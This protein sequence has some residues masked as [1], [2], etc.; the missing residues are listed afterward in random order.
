MSNGSYS[1][2]AHDHLKRGIALC[3]E[4]LALTPRLY[5]ALYHLALAQ[6]G[7]KQPDDALTTYQRALDVCSAKGVVQETLQ[8]LELLT[9]AS[10]STEGTEPVYKLLIKSI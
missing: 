5:D 4:Q 10:P 1:E 9:Q 3:Q 8:D 7:V 2:E 6:L